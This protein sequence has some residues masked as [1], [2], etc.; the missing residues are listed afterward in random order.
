MMKHLK[1]TLFA[2]DL[3]ENADT[4][5]CLHISATT[6]AKTELVLLFLNIFIT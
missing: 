6:N 5:N 3:D 1:N 2:R 4:T